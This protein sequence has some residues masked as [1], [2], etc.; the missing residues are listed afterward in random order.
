MLLLYKAVSNPC[1]KKEETN[2]VVTAATAPTTE[3][4]VLLEMLTVTTV[5]DVATSVVFTDNAREFLTNALQP[6]ANLPAM[7]MYLPR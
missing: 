7:T 6:C 1:H 4:T 3:K 5:T 2:T